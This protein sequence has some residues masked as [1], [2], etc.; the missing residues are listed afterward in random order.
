MLPRSLGGHAAEADDDTLWIDDAF[1]MIVLA[2]RP[3]RPFQGNDFYRECGDAFASFGVDN[4]EVRSEVAM[5][6][7][8]APAVPDALVTKLSTTF[9]KLR[10]LAESPQAWEQRDEARLAYPYSARELPR[11]NRWSGYSRQTSNLSSSVT[12][13]SIRLT[14]GRI[15]RS[16]RVLKTV[17][18]APMEL[19]WT[20]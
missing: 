7:A 19:G 13:K 6:K 8:Y 10:D 18:Y 11:R 3:G 16:R 12:S 5:L 9:G 20:M 1:R 4:P 14:F 15:D 17:A 2:N